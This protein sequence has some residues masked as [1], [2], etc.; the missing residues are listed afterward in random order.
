M[1]HFSAEPTFFTVI[2]CDVPFRT[3]IDVDTRDKYLLCIENHTI[4]KSRSIIS[5][6]KLNSF[7]LVLQLRC[8]LQHK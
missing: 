8:S 6:T 1:V 3:G 2:L 4:N 7:I 5:V